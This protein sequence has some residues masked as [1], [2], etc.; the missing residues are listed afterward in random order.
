[1]SPCTL[2]GGYQ[3]GGGGGGGYRGGGGGGGRVQGAGWDRGRMTI[4]LPLA[5]LVKCEKTYLF[6][7]YFSILLSITFFRQMFCYFVL[8]QFSKIE[9]SHNQKLCVDI[10]ISL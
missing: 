2:G 3:G 8:Y 1:M 5:S 9:S 7:F 10:T 6:A 4:R